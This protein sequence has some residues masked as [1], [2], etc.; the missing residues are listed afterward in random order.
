MT[1][2]ILDALGATLLGAII[3]WTAWLAVDRHM[4]WVDARDREA[5][6]RGPCVCECGGE[7]P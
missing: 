7:R 4:A 2:R 3:V 1:R 6:E 5:W